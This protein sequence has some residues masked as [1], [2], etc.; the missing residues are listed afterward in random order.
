MSN[1]P[2]A[3]TSL[4]FDH[5]HL[6]SSTSNPSSLKKPFSTAQKIGASQVMPIYPTRIFVRFSPPV[7]DVA[8]LVLHPTPNRLALTTAAR[9]V[10]ETG[11][12]AVSTPKWEKK[13]EIAASEEAYFRESRQ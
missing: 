10:L 9:R 1:P 2:S 5:S 13:A 7:G 8:L 12:V 6:T 11:M 4:Y 3:S